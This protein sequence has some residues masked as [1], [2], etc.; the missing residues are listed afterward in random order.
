MA[1]AP[2]QTRYHRSVGWHGVGGWDLAALVF[3]VAVW[4]IIRRA[5]GDQTVRLSQ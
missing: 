5:D 3:L 4:P 1:G 2:R